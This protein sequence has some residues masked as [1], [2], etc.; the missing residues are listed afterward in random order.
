MGQVSF[1]CF[2]VCLFV[3]FVFFFFAFGKS[4][5]SQYTSVFNLTLRFCQKSADCIH[6]DLCVY[7]VS[8]VYVIIS[9]CQHHVVL[10][11]VTL[12]E[13]LK[14]SG[15]VFQLCSSFSNDV[16]TWA[17]LPF[18]II[19][20]SFQI[21]LELACSYGREA[22][23]GCGLGLPWTFYRP[24]WRSLTPEQYSNLWTWSSSP[25]TYSLLNF[26][27]QYFDSPH[28]SIFSEMYTSV[29]TIY[30]IANHTFK[31]HFSIPIICCYYIEMHLILIILDLH[32]STLLNSLIVLGDLCGFLGIFHVDSHILC[33]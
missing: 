5:C 12:K 19:F 10:I 13:I 28:M 25:F 32:T 20:F 11:T 22:P 4:S 3:L 18:Q 26:S 24:G 27:H 15:E 1:L 9:L 17:P 29:F 7:S 14:S 8:L 2:F 33:E 16:D 21:I 31:Q 30:S 23:T 6:G